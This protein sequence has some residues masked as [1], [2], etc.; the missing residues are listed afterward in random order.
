MTVKQTAEYGQLRLRQLVSAHWA[1]FRR[2]TL[3]IMYS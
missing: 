2:M 3:A 1:P